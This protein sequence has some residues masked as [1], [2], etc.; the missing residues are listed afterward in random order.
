MRI[1]C[2]IRGLIRSKLLG[3]IYADDSPKRYSHIRLAPVATWQP[4]PSLQEKTT[5]LKLEIQLRKKKIIWFNEYCFIF[6]KV[7]DCLIL[8]LPY[9]FF[10]SLEKSKSFILKVIPNIT[11]G[12]LLFLM[13]CF[14]QGLLPLFANKPCIICSPPLPPMNVDNTSDDRDNKQTQ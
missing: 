12:L 4:G 13:D 6:I 7:A 2:A 3:G 9:Y 5:I 1:S 8:R 10:S 11:C 14:F